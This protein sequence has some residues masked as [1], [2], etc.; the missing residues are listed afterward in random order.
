MNQQVFRIRNHFLV[1][2]A[3][4]VLLL[5][6]LLLLSVFYKGSS[7]ERMVLAVIFVPAV[8]IFLESYSR[9]V[10]TDDNGIA[11]RKFLREKNFQWQEITHVGLLVMRSKAYFLL[12]TTKGF[13]VLSNAYEKHEEMIRHLSD[14]LDGEKVDEN[15]REQ[16]AAPMRNLSDVVGAWIA[17]IVLAGIIAVKFFPL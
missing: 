10:T 5:L 14:H 3:I 9:R 15:V 11:I 6:I 12:T 13:Y 7:T 8:L 16:V 4:D 1:P 17:L 2:L